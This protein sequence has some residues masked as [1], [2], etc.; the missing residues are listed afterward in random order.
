MPTI[1]ATS[2][3]VWDQDAPDVATAQA[4]TYQVF[5]DGVQVTTW[6]SNLVV[7]ATPIVGTQLATASFPPL[8]VGNHS[9][10]LTATNAVG[11]SAQSVALAVTVLGV[12]AI[13]KNLR[14]Q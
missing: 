7:I 4:Y 9:I 13:P 6:V 11:A 2:K 1:T 14:V 8:S 10:T 3:L 5:V 12:P